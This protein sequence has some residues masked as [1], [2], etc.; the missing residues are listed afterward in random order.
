LT[1]PSVI[2]LDGTAAA[3]KST[4]GR[5]LAERLGY[6]CF[7]SGLLYRAVTW[8]ALQRG[9]RI[10]NQETIEQL[11]A[12]LRIDVLPP[13]IADGRAVTVLVDG[14]DVTWELNTPEVDRHVSPVS[15]YPGVRRVLLAQQ[16]AIGARGRVVML[17]RDIGT[18]VMPEADFKLFVDAAVEVR[19]QRRYAE[20]MARGIVVSYEDVLTQMS[21]RDRSDRMKPIS[22][23][24]PAPDAIV[25]DTTALTLEEVLEH[26]MGLLRERSGFGVGG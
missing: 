5:L 15:A 26:V 12:E 22:P 9:V 19:A 17:G 7:D 1:Y 6:L 14:E 25:V 21:A 4:L 18:V 2:A 16:R 20:N 3:G 13:A 10:G 24:V 11:A 8:A 23:M